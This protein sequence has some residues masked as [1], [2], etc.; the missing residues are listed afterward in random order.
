M[1]FADTSVADRSM[2]CSNPVLKSFYQ[3]VLDGKVSTWLKL[4]T[5]LLEYRELGTL[6]DEKA[7]GV[8]ILI[9]AAK[10]DTVGV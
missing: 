9:E 8:V 5:F 4:K 3:F 1:S 10:G 7:E 6:A 2:K